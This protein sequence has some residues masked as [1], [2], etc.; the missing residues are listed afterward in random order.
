MRRSARFV[1]NRSVKKRVVPRVPS[2]RQPSLSPR[3]WCGKL[4]GIPCFIMGNAPSLNK[5]K[6]FSIFDDYFTVGIN[7]VF[8]KYDPTILI[9]QDL[10]LWSQEN[11]RVK[12]LRAIKYCRE[13]SE[14][15]G[16]KYTFKLNG[17]ESKLSHSTD[18]LYGR[19]SSGAISYQFVH[20]LKCDPIILVGMDC[21]YDK[22]T[23][24]TDFYGKNSMHKRHTLPDC[25]SGL[26]FIKQNSSGKTILNCSDNKVFS[27]RY[28][29]EEVVEMIKDKKTSREEIE[30]LLLS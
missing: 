14:T 29:I 11:K 5:I 9:W 1:K 22:K 4:E 3:N 20:A 18:T 30:N 10:A 21:R 2:K 19:G 12:Q 17:R 24:D 26:K 8:F 25:V 7:R 13:G 27:E 23:G 16:G 6:D 28:T 15:E